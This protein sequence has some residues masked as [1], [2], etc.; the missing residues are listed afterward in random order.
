M[1]KV[2]K[3]NMPMLT[4]TLT[5]P[6][7]TEFVDNL[8]SWYGKDIQDD[9]S[10]FKWFWTVQN[11]TA[12]EYH[13]QMEEEDVHPDPDEQEKDGGD[14]D[15]L[16][17]SHTFTILDEQEPEPS[18]APIAVHPSGPG[19]HAEK[20]SDDDDD[21]DDDNKDDD[22]DD[23]DNKDDD[24]DD[25]D[26]T[27]KE[28]PTTQTPNPLQVV[29]QLVSPQQSSQPQQ[30]QEQQQQQ[31]QQTPPAT[32]PATQPATQPEQVN[33]QPQPEP[34]QETVQGGNSPIVD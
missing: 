6:C 16:V 19:D 23:D 12:G 34:K 3:L 24:D 22:D 1:Q 20:K 17:R 10:D 30:E 18:N 8:K 25:D 32:P 31:Q 28:Q 9:N 14:Q 27:S 29:G 15:D 2:A 5:C 26:D 11:V 4:C 13:V 21:D 33:P 7:S